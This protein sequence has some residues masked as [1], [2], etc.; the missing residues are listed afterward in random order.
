[1]FGEDQKVWVDVQFAEVALAAGENI[2]TLKTTGAGY[3]IS[4]NVDSNITLAAKAA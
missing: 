2:I 1:M 3:R 4:I